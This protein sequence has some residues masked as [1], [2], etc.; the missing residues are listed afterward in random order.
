VILE[1]VG[2]VVVL[3]D[4][5]IWVAAFGGAAVVQLFGSAVGVA[6]AVE[7]RRLAPASPLSW[8]ALAVG[9]LSSLATI[10][11]LLTGAFA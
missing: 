5:P 1:E 7:A 9:G 11:L 8:G 3:D 6:L 4:H 2:G 10:S